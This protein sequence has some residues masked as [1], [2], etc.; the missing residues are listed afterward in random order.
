[1][2]GKENCAPLKY[3]NHDQ[4]CAFVI[5]DVVVFR[6]QTIHSICVFFLFL[7]TTLLILFDV[8]TTVIRKLQS[9]QKIKTH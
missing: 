3:I 2:S 8:L 1:M 9:G 6:I 5:D 4:I 7:F